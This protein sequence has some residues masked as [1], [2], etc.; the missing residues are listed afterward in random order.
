LSC[1]DFPV[2][3]LCGGRGRRLRPLT[4]SI[5][6]P[7]VSLA[8]KPLLGYII[9]ALRAQGARRLVFCV[10]YRA[11]AVVDFAQKYCDPDQF[12]IDF[13]DSGANADIVV[14]LRDAARAAPDGF[15]FLY[16]DAIADV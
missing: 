3:I 7:L 14:R 12:N 15:F 10:G 9:D 6:K 11:Q 5:P 8:G 1:P 16:G 2:I 13:V 4:D